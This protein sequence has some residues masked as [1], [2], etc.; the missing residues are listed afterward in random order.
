MERVRIRTKQIEAPARWPK[1]YE[2]VGVCLCVRA[3]R[4]AL[5]VNITLPQPLSNPSRGLASAGAGVRSFGGQ[6]LRY[7]DSIPDTCASTPPP[8]PAGITRRR[9]ARRGRRLPRTAL[10]TQRGGKRARNRYKQ[11]T[12]LVE[13]LYLCRVVECA[14]E[15]AAAAALAA[16]LGRA[17]AAHRTLFEALFEDAHSSDLEWS[18]RS[19]KYLCKF[20]RQKYGERASVCRELEKYCGRL[21]LRCLLRAPHRWVSGRRRA[22]TSQFG[23]RPYTRN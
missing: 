19:I 5:S 8:G 7:R 16:S 3:R 9:R 13:V 1:D 11:R 17:P 23:A 4:R 20:N 12:K 18:S 22:H 10:L 14:G 15:A 21:G 2:V 6:L